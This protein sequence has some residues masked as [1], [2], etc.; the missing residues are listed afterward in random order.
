MLLGY[1]LEL[2]EAEETFVLDSL[3]FIECGDETKLLIA[4][5]FSGWDG[6]IIL[7]HEMTED[8]LYSCISRL[9]QRHIRTSTT[10]RTMEYEDQP[11]LG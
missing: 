2:P 1:S 4:Q 6:S 7:K 5:N 9:Q 11:I 10:V 8:E 3:P